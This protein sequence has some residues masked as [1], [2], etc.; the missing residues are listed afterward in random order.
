[1]QG[2]LQL[3]YIGGSH[4]NNFSIPLGFGKPGAAPSSPC[5]SSSLTRWGI[6]RPSLCSRSEQHRAARDDPIIS[7][8][9]DDRGLPISLYIYPFSLPPPPRT[10][11]HPPTTDSS[12]LVFGSTGPAFH[13]RK[14]FDPIRPTCIHELSEPTLRLLST[15]I[16]RISN[17]IPTSGSP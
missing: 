5:S 17:I 3:S 16:P 10:L 2:G 11:P 13:T 4:S 9:K 6:P 14:F 8:A 15:F 12:S 7:R 1:M